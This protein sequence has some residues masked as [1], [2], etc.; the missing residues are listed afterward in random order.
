MGLTFL[1]LAKKVLLET[2]RPMDA[3]DIWDY[4]AEKEY[5]QQLNSSGRTPWATLAAQLYVGVKGT[6][7]GRDFG[8][9]DGRPKQFYLHSIDYP[10]GVLQE[11]EK[12]ELDKLAA[13]EKELRKK[14]YLE[15]DL[16][17]VLAYFARYYLRCYTK[18]INHSRSGKQAYGEWVHP[19]MVGCYFPSEDRSAEVNELTEAIGGDSVN[20]FS[21]ELKRK[22]TFSN[23]RAAFFQTVSNSSWAH[24][25]YLVT[26]ELSSDAELRNEL[27]RLSSA[28]GIGVI[29]LDVRE[30]DDSIIHLP[31]R[32]STTLDWDTIDKL[33]VNE[34]F[35]DFLYRI[36]N[37]VRSREIRE[38][39]YDTVHDKDQ[40]VKKFR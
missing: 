23:L 22:L 8:A 5:D 3:N 2:R 4:A 10:P 36:K 37:D 31:A 25:S 38:E 34:D 28:F 30:P 26:A 7:R 18:T 40:L 13:E 19:D 24:D 16:H 11:A 33:T 1:Q 21:F 6:R 15:K 17:P 35:K 20:L 9:T 39:L 29:V 32:S 27:K 14:E 12:A